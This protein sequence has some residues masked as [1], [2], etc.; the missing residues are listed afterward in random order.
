MEYERGAAMFKNLNIGHLLVLGISVVL[1]LVTLVNTPL[2][3]STATSIVEDAEQQKLA[4]LFTSAEVEIGSEGRIASALATFVAH[5]D[6]LN[7]KF[8]N[9][10]RD[11]LAEMLVPAYKS[12]KT[13]FSARQFQY[14][15]PPATSFLRLHKPE[16]FGDDLSSF[17][18]TVV[19]SNRNKAVIVGLEKGVAGLGIR[20]ISPVSYKGQHVG[21]VEFGMSF[22]QPFFENFKRKYNV[23]ISLYLKNSDGFKKFGST[24]QNATLLSPDELQQALNNPVLVEREY[25][26]LELAV[27]GY[28]ISDYEGKTIGVLEIGMDR[29]Q[30]AKAISSARNTAI[31]VGIVSILIGLAVALFIARQITRPL[32]LTVATMN[33]IAEGDGDL[34]RRLNVEGSNEISQLSQAFNAFAERVHKIVSQVA[35]ATLQLSSAAEEL[36]KIMDETKRNTSQQQ[37]DT[38]QVV[39]AMN[40]ME[41]TVNEVARHTTEA[42]VAAGNADSASADGK[43]VVG[44]TMSSI[45][46]LAAEVDSA[47][48]VIT[49]LERD[50]DR[51]GSV[52][53]VIK[54]IAEQT[55]LLALNAAIEAARAG[56]QGRGFAVVADEVRSL[57]SKTQKSTEEI[58]KMIEDLQG[59]SRSAVNAMN[60]SRSKASSSVSLAENA[61]NSIEAIT[62][63]VA[64]IRDM[65]TQIATAAEEQSA[66]AKEV[67]RNILNISEISKLSVVGA[68][69]AAIASDELAKLAAELQDMVNQFKV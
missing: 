45:E 27:Y 61:G 59:G 28:K 18:N 3:I 57:A 30:Y 19:E 65:N 25:G 64:L 17:R 14:H 46:S 7:E 53:D 37:S 38:S 5:I 54:G 34:T 29:S 33:E 6:V 44:K 52:L 69:Q 50:S 35:R 9:G 36:S 41:S 20:G 13:D 8:A 67:N 58:Q 42:S 40:E 56:E 49:Q 43:I 16:K 68:N 55:N 48:N 1:I 47:A 21:S 23:D 2:M 24:V 4:S 12:V 11:E 63:S 60:D 15:L 10:Q 39:T 31:I 66:V 26:D 62:H 51:I 22:G 32:D